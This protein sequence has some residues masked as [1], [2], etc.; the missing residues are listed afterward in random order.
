MLATG[1]VSEIIGFFIIWRISD[2]KV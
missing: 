1:L 2:I